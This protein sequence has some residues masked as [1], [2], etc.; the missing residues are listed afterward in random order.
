MSAEKKLA[1]AILFSADPTMVIME[2][3]VAHLR[4]NRELYWAAG[5]ESTGKT[6][7]SQSLGSLMLA[8]RA[9][10]LAEINDII[11][12]LVEHFNDASIKPASF[13]DRWEKNPQERLHPLENGCL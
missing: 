4:I 1:K 5:F 3:A 2:D 6:F 9:C 11:P 10:F 8:V 13:R 7:N 12:F